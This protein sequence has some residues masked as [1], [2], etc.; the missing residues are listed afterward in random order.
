MDLIQCPSQSAGAVTYLLGTLIQTLLVNQCAVSPN[1]KWPKDYGYDA[2]NGNLAEYDFIVIGGGSAGS[3]VASRLSEN[4]EWK[5]LLLE[6]GDNPPNESE[7]PGLTPNIYANQKFTFQFPTEADACY[8]YENNGCFYP[9]GKLLGG[10][11]AINSMIH[12]RGNENDYNKWNE[13]GLDKWDWK[14]ILEYF[15]LSENNENFGN[16]FIYHGSS[17]PLPV[18]IYNNTPFLSDVF[19]E[20]YEKGFNLRRLIDFNTGKNVGYGFLQGTIQNGERYTTAKSFLKNR[21]NLHIIRNAVVNKILFENNTAV[22]VKFKIGNSFDIAV[23]AEKEIILSAGVISSAQL[24]QVSGIGP[25]KVLKKARVPVRKYLPVGENLHD[26]IYTILIFKLRPSNSTFFNLKMEMDGIYFY[27]RDKTGPYSSISAGSFAAFA[28]FV[29]S[30]SSYANLHL[31]HSGYERKS[32]SFIN[33]VN[34]FIEPVRS[35]LINQGEKSD[36]AIAFIGLLNAESRG[37]IKIKTSSI[38]DNPNISLNYLS[39]KN[40]V[41]ILTQAIR[42]YIALSNSD[43]FVKNEMKLLKLPLPGCSE[44]NYGSDEYWECYIRHAVQPGWH[45]VGT[46]KMGLIK[47]KGTVVSQKLKVKGFNRLR[48]IDAGVMPE[49]VSANVNGAVIMIAERGADLIKEEWNFPTKLIF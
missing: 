2:L 36:M 6:A 29:N 8:I 21:S 41:K 32:P 46:S 3:V 45:A 13:I 10:S 24:L 35:Y 22:G 28:N 44:L 5:V 7:I 11:H 40:D 20:I 49:T 39:S 15:K 18:S 47:E 48:Q 27:L 14:T 1:D 37:Q 25:R 31:L 30:T 33:T 19:A 9:R 17:G 38:N 42:K 43:I 23:K 12:L 16:D 34:G 4:S 26:H